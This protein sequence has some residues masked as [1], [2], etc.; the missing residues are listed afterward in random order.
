MLLK[1]LNVTYHSK[2]PL[3]NIEQGDIKKDNF[4]EYENKF[5]ITKS[6]FPKTTKKLSS[7]YR[8][9]LGKYI[10]INLNFLNQILSK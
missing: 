2:I 5:K 4:E 8:L 6:K 7:D 1:Q 10:D 3:F 9:D